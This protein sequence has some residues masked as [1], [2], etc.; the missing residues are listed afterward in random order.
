[1][2]IQSL[3]PESLCPPYKKPKN[4]SLVCNN[5]RVGIKNAYACGISCERGFGFA[6]L[7]TSKKVH[8]YYLCMDDGKWYGADAS[9]P[10]PI[11]L[12]SGR[13][14]SD[15]SGMYNGTL[16]LRCHLRLYDKNSCSNHPHIK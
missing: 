10:T 16:L 1:M 9:P 2:H 6:K 3:E 12:P 7:A 14:W 5:M 4:G 13:P 15:C 11:P 8:N